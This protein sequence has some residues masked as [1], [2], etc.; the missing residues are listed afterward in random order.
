MLMRHHI[1]A[2]SSAY[3]I[4]KYDPFATGETGPFG[5]AIR[6]MRSQYV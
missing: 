5:P 2:P 1:I 4:G 6:R 3:N